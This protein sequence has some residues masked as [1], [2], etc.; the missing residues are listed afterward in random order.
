M[1]KTLTKTLSEN[2][3]VKVGTRSFPSPEVKDVRLDDQAIEN[4]H[5]QT[6]KQ[7]SQDLAS[8][9]WDRMDLTAMP[10][11]EQLRSRLFAAYTESVRKLRESRSEAMK[12]FYATVETAFFH[13]L[14]DEGADFI[15]EVLSVGRVTLT[16][17]QSIAS[18]E[19]GT[20]SLDELRLHLERSLRHEISRFVKE[21]FE[22]LDRLVDRSAVGLVHWTGTNSVRYHFF[23][24]SIG[25]TGEETTRDVG[26][27]EP[28]FNLGVGPDSQRTAKITTRKDVTCWLDHHRHDTI[29]AIQ[30][31]IENSNVPTP[32][33]VVALTDQIPA[34]LR[35]LVTIIDGYLVR[36]RISRQEICKST[37]T[38]VEFEEELLYGHEP[39]V[40]L[41]PYVLTG[42]GPR[43]IENMEETLQVADGQSTAARSRMFWITASVAATSLAWL[44]AFTSQSLFALACLVFLAGVGCFVTGLTNHFRLQGRALSQWR[45][46]FT[47]AGPVML[48]GGML[49]LAPSWNGYQLLLTCVLILVGIGTTL[50]AAHLNNLPS[51][52]GDSDE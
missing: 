51:P 15:N 18:A 24:R 37:I 4:I 8:Q 7:I 22:S 36:E 47:A 31:S 10:A 12:L 38:Q 50:A 23:R 46:Q 26:R 19:H 16:Q 52:Q 21:F 35:P 11:D 48:A 41:G 2:F 27:I 30:T 17:P 33:F 49:N 3:G 42:W 14:G 5:D 44:L 40:C 39:A 43:D 45:L 28:R 6:A 1:S 29:D 25:V 32:P 13:D 20:L 9:I 34:W